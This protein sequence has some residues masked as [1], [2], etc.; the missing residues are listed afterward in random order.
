MPNDEKKLTQST[1]LHGREGP[2]AFTNDAVGAGHGDRA[3]DR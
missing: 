1:P 2:A 3:G